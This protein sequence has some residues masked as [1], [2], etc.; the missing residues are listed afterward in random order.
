MTTYVRL[1]F[2]THNKKMQ[3]ENDL[4][5]EIKYNQETILLVSCVCFI[6]HMC[7]VKKFRFVTLCQEKSEVCDKIIF[8]DYQLKYFYVHVVM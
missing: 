5:N 1:F 4:L 7:N 3:T 6:S 2:I 8:C